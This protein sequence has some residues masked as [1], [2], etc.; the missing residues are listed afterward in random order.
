MGEILN[1]KQGEFDLG[2]LYEESLDNSA[3]R[4]YGKYYTGDFIIDFILE[5]TTSDIDVV[6]NPFIKVLDPACGAGFFLLKAYDILKDK[7][8][9]KLPILKETYASKTYNIYKDGQSEVV[10]GYEYWVSDN[11]HYHILKNCIFGADIDEKALRLCSAALNAKEQNGGVFDLNILYCDSLVRW[12]EDYEH[13][14]IMDELAEYKLI[15]TIRNARR[16]EISYLTGDEAEL[17]LK[18]HEFWSNRFDLIIGNP[19]YVGHKEL[20]M[21]YKRWLIKNYDEVF[22]DK[23]DLS[24]CFYQRAL[25]LAKDKTI[26]S[27]ISSRYFIESP[28]GRNLRRYLKNNSKLIQIVDFSGEK[29]FPD[30]GVA[31]AIFFIASELDKENMVTVWKYKGKKLARIDSKDFEIFSISQKGLLDDRWIFVS[32]ENENILNKIKSK[33]KARLGDVVYSFQGIITGCD[34]AFVL[35]DNIAK[36][37]NIEKEL[38]RPWIKNSHV[39]KYKISKSKYML[40]YSDLIKEPKDYP[41]SMAQISKYKEQLEKRRECRNGVRLWYELQWGRKEELFL[42]DKIVYPFKSKSNRFA[43]DTKGSFCSADV[44]SFVLKENVKGYTLPFLLGV[45]NSTLYEFYFKIFAKEMGSG[46]YDYYP[47]SVM[48]LKLPDYEKCK[49]IEDIAIEL[50]KLY[51][52][53]GA[54][55]DKDALEAQI[56]RILNEYYGIE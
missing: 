8:K 23:S 2:K 16:E 19:P 52:K 14:Q 46:V 53:T 25:E 7:F 18:R 56:D 21:N 5:K 22:F 55:E 33:G 10:R 44:Y 49:K 31:T 54:K 28:T 41:N 35:E 6:K 20:S 34:K 11:L 37:L 24:Y 4:S 26:I 3:K 51:E 43:L 1:G 39:D 38:L 9:S 30:A 13:K 50:T 12:D 29:V 40:I 36:Y 48:D 27:F 17:I 47:N 45:L 32:D 42:K 15:Y